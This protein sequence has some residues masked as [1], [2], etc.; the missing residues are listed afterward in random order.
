MPPNR[1]HYD[2]INARERAIIELDALPKDRTHPFADVPREQ[3]L[4]MREE[5]LA[6]RTKE[7]IPKPKP[8]VNTTAVQ[9]LKRQ[10][11][12][13]LVKDAYRAKIAAENSNSARVAKE[14]ATEEER[15]LN[16]AD[17]IV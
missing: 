6:A 7:I 4:R 3:A 10:K 2:Y 9:N 8:V 17:G 15:L 12:E 5:Y 16:Q 14:L 13:R 1:T 11:R